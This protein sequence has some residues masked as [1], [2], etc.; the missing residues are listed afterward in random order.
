MI[1]VG[2]IECCTMYTTT[3]SNWAVDDDLL[4]QSSCEVE[5]SLAVGDYKI[6]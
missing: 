4:V 6:G 3:T 5:F 1:L 2:V